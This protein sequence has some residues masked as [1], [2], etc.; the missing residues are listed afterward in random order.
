MYAIIMILERFKRDGR[1]GVAVMV[2]LMAPALLGFAALAVD[3]GFWMSSQSADQLSSDAVAM[4]VAR[5]ALYGCTSSS[6]V[7]NTA[8]AAASSAI[9]MDAPHVAA[10][11]SGTTTGQ[12]DAR[13]TTTITPQKFLIQAV[14][15]ASAPARLSASA[16]AKLGQIETSSGSTAYTP[17]LVR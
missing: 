17:F 12:Y 16:S 5:S 6:C 9:S 3:V 13:A 7:S 8:S 10:S 2:A 4:A 15:G 11:L 14:I 1:A